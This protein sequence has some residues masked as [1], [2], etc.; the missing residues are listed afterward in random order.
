MCISIAVGADPAKGS[1][2]IGESIESTISG[3]LSCGGT[4]LGGAT[5]NLSGLSRGYSVTTDP[6]GNYDKGI[7]VAAGQTLTITAHYAGDSNH[8]PASATT[9]ISIREKDS[10]RFIPE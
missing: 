1:L 9:T 6:S 10:G 3:Q 8:G 2:S 5:I 4:G 7:L